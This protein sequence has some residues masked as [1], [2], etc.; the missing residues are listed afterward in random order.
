MAIQLGLKSVVDSPTYEWPKPAPAACTAL[1]CFTAGD[2]ETDIFYVVSNTIYKY[3]CV[4]DGWIQLASATGPTPATTLAAKYKQNGGIFGRAI[5]GGASTITGAFLYG[6][7]LKGE[8]IKI[9][10]GTGAG[11]T[12]VISDVADPVAADY[13]CCTTA[14]TTAMVDSAKAYAMNAYAGYQLR[15][16]AGTG[17][18]QTRQIL[19]NNA[20]TCTF[21][22]AL[23]A[24]SCPMLPWGATWATTAIAAPASVAVIESCVATVDRQ[25]DTQPDNTSIYQIDSGSIYVMNSATAGDYCYFMKYDIAGDRWELKSNPKGF[26]AAA[27]GADWSLERIGSAVMPSAYATGTATGGTA[28]TLADS[29]K[30]FSA[31]QYVNCR[32]KIVSGTGAGQQRTIL[33]HD[34]NTLT[35]AIPWKVT[36]TNGSSV[37][38]IWPDS[39]K[40]YLHG[41]GYSLLAQYSLEVDNWAIARIR[42][43]GICATLIACDGNGTCIPIAESNGITRSSTTATVTTAWSHPWKTGQTITIR[44]AVQAD[45]NITA[46]ITVTSLTAFTYTVANSPAT[47]ATVTQAFTSSILVDGSKNWTINEHAGRICYLPS[48]STFQKITSNTA[49]ALTLSKAIT[50]PTAAASGKYLIMDPIA[51]GANDTGTAATS[52]YGVPTS[53][54]TTAV[55]Q[56]GKTWTINK[57]AG[58]Q[59]RIIAGTGIN[60]NFTINTNTATALAM[61]A[62]TTGP[63]T[64][65]IYAVYDN[66]PPGAGVRLFW[67]YGCSDPNI[68]GRYIYRVRG[69]AT[70]TIDRY[71][72]R[73]QTWDLLFSYPSFETFTTGTASTYD[74]GDRIYIQKD[75][76]GRL[77]YYD[78]V[79]NMVVPAPQTPYTQGTVLLGNRMEII[80]SPDGAKFLYYMRNSDSVWYRTMLFG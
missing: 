65:S 43:N 6:N 68:A 11:Q 13:M 70:A 63:S 72:L 79:K 38:E 33:S 31:S 78:I 66:L 42:D 80:Q 51:F 8:T 47:P 61:T 53:G 9:I 45:Y 62:I 76:T 74:G 23:Y 41:S 2:I 16:V 20:T 57:F 26:L 24:H 17:I 69:G 5:A 30:T 49:S 50:Q 25:W 27:L 52:G 37:Y 46:T 15:I 3:N 22:D 7:R 77:Y 60:Q 54:S 71:D 14:S 21:S 56:T 64:D 34:T 18:G 29:S 73:T 48:Q 28:T 1:S 10:A 75:N 36:P 59:C 58:K 4:T 35:V 40:M 44:G 19:Y 32:V 39:D 12:R 55:T 67:V